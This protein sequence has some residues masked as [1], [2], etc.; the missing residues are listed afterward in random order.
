MD[1]VSVSVNM[2]MESSNP[3]EAPLS[4]TASMPQGSGSIDHFVDLPVSSAP[5]PSLS[6]SSNSN[7]NSNSNNS[8]NNSSGGLGLGA[9]SMAA[10]AVRAMSP[11]APPSNDANAAQHRYNST[12]VYIFCHCHSSLKFCV[13][14]TARFFH[15]FFKLAA[16]AIYMFGGLIDNFVIGIFHCLLLPLTIRRSMDDINVSGINI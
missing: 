12:C 6:S 5:T 2:S 16:L 10:A 4:G 11:P 9:V 14:S 3:F 15:M 7:M 8:N 13:N 1:N